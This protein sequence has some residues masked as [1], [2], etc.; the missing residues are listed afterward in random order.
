MWEVAFL[1]HATVGVAGSAGEFT[2][3]ATASTL[4]GLTGGHSHLE[5]VLRH[6]E[7][8]A[9]CAT[10]I[11]GLNPATWGRI[12]HLVLQGQPGHSC[13]SSPSVQLDRLNICGGCRPWAEVHV[14]R[15]GPEQLEPAAGTVRRR[16]TLVAPLGESRRHGQQHLLTRTHAL[17]SMCG[18]ARHGAHN[19]SRV[20][21]EAH[22]VSR[23]AHRAVIQRGGR[24]ASWATCRSPWRNVDAT[25]CCNAPGLRAWEGVLA[26]GTPAGRGMWARRARQAARITP[27]IRRLAIPVRERPATT[28]RARDPI[29][30]WRRPPA[31]T[32][33]AG[34]GRPGVHRF[35]DSEGPG[36]DRFTA[37]GRPGV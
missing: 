13:S 37:P 15:S 35:K 9:R 20:T 25:G 21:I 22:R 30:R 16:C 23:R 29:F 33:F 36:G 27:E 19:R 14:G 1:A 2:G 6:P 32:A 3:I 7:G 34:S 26:S 4:R 12:L 10:R 18:R 28:G 31:A 5:G 24:G 11:P 17:H 8:G